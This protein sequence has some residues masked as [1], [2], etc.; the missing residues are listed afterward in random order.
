MLQ[1]QYYSNMTD[2]CSGGCNVTSDI[3][4]CEA[5]VKHKMSRKQF[6]STEGVKSTRLLELVNTAVCGPMQVKS[7]GDS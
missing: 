4:I 1:L 3:G 6:H 2:W 5:C 7:L